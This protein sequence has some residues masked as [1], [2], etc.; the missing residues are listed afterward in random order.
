MFKYQITKVGRKWYEAVT[1]DEKH[2][3]AQIEINEVS[4][5]W[6]V[7]QIVEFEGKFERKTSGKFT[8]TYV[9]PC[10]S[11]QKEQ[12]R[13]YIQNQRE[14]QEIEKWLGYVESNSAEYVYQNGVDKLREMNLS[15]EQKNRLNTA[16]T[17]GTINAA[18]KRINDYFG[19]IKNSVSEGKWYDKGETIVKEN[20]IILQNNNINTDKYQDKLNELKELKR[21]NEKINAER[22]F[23]IQRPS[24]FKND[25]IGIGEIWQNHDGRIGKVIK[26]WKYFEE[27]GMSFGYYDDNVWLCCAKCDTAIVTVKEKEE[28]LEQKEIE[29]QAEQRRKEQVQKKREMEKQVD[30]LFNYVRENGRYPEK[31]NNEQIMVTGDVI[32][33][34]FNIYGGGQKIVIDGTNIWTLRNNGMDGDNWSYNNIRTGGAGA[35]G[36]CMEMDDI[37]KGYVI[38]IRN[39]FKDEK[40]E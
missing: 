12:Q 8:K 2:Y 3:K 34:T 4:K 5:G 35:I 26:Q 9:Y 14:Q 37:C 19:Y 24:M 38:K 15:E 33:D 30:E 28:Y 29:K 39:Y 22:Y 17:A 31:V 32:Y 11:E 20:I 25:Q 23:T 36:H 40:G 21:Q 6:Q 27:D 16:I 13:Q 10:T 18:K 7:D 1:A